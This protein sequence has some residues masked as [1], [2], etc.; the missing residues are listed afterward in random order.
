MGLWLNAN[1]SPSLRWDRD[2]L[3]IGFL[4]LVFAGLLSIYL[5]RRSLRSQAQPAAERASSRLENGA[6]GVVALPQE[7]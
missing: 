5:R 6:P 3:A 7:D 2:G 4:A 1:I